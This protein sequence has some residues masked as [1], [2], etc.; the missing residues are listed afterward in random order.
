LNFFKKCKENG[1][2]TSVD[3]SDISIKKFGV[4]KLS[5]LSKIEKLGIY[6]LRLDSGFTT[7]EII[8]LTNNKNKIK[9]ELNASMTTELDKLLDLINKKGNIKN[10]LACHNFFP[11]EFTGLS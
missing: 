3:V 5:D 4:D 9:I 11:R 6:S 7:D 10:V 1:L 2:S 8:E